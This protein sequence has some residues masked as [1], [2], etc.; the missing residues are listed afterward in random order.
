MRWVR[1]SGVEFS[2]YLNQMRF[3]DIHGLMVRANACFAV[4]KPAKTID[5]NAPAYQAIWL[6]Q[7]DEIRFC[8]ERCFSVHSKK[9]SHAIDAVY[10]HV[11][12]A[13]C[14][15]KHVVCREMLKNAMA[16]S[17]AQFSDQSAVFF[18]RSVH[19]NN[20]RR[21]RILRAHERPR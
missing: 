21:K 4:V 11:L 1:S 18:I 8:S 15:R 5:W 20:Q 7:H 12:T 9:L 17:G 3:H 10:V 16:N 14:A 2:H 6:Q 13:R 19:R